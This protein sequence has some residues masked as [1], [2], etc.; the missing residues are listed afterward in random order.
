VITA[1][2]RAVVVAHEVQPATILLLRPGRL[3]KTTS[4]KIQRQATK[5][6]FLDGTLEV[7]QRWSLQPASATNVTA[8]ASPVVPATASVQTWLVTQLAHRLQVAP[9]TIDL[10]Q[11]FVDLG[12]D[13]LAAVEVVEQLRLWLAQQDRVVALEPTLLWDFPTIAALATHLDQPLPVAFSHSAP[14][15]QIA[16]LPVNGGAQFDPTQAGRGSIPVAALDDDLLAEI[17]RL[18][19]LLSQ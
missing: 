11:P 18:E 7:E 1:I 4:G 12:L 8:S 16:N 17:N 5:Q 14:R 9:Q 19:K 13:S 6:A 3:L 15:K 10:H 2:R